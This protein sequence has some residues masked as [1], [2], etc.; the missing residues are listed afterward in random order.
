MQLSLERIEVLLLIAAVVAMLARRL[1]LPYTIGLTLAGAALAFAPVSV[2]VRLTKD[3]IF[4][5]FL[6]PLIFEAALHMEW[7]AL[8]REAPVVLV[9]ATLGVL[10]AGGIMAAGLHHLAAWP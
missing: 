4:N 1:R 10:V 5:A 9:L 3:L 7:R 6:P 8:R 2:E